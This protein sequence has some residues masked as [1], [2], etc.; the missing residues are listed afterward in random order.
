MNIKQRNNTITML[1]LFEGLSINNLG[2]IFGLVPR[3]IRE[4]INNNL[5]NKDIGCPPWYK[6]IQ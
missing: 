3:T 5:K 4:I 1:F 2:L 6:Q